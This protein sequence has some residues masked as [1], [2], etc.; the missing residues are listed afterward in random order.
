MGDQAIN[1]V[2]GLAIAFTVGY[3]AG[4]AIGYFDRGRFISTPQPRDS[5]GRFT[6][7]S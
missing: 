3:W 2:V 5:R 6:K 1:F 7:A 4:Y